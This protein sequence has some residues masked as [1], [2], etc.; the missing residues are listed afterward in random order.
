MKM[1]TAASRVELDVRVVELEYFRRKSNVAP[2]VYTDGAP[3]IGQSE[4]PISL[5]ACYTAQMRSTNIL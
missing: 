5:I 3:K 1:K 4:A 2:N